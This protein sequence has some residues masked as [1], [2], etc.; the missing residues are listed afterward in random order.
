MLQDAAVR[1]GDMDFSPRTRR[2]VLVANRFRWEGKGGARIHGPERV[3]CGLRVD[4]VRTVAFQG[5][6]RNSRD[7][8]LD[9]LTIGWQA[10]DDGGSLDMIFAGGAALRLTVEAIAVELRDLTDPW[11]ARS[12][13]HH[14][15]P[16]RNTKTGND[17]P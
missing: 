12:R 10:A 9:L 7:Q 16:D 15:A 1:V 6:S 13:P 17:G 4:G 8:V 5:F 3:R 2:F 11:P 14:D